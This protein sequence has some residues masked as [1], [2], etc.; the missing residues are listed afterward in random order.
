MQSNRVSFLRGKRMRATLLNGAAIPLVGD[1][2]VVTTKGFV[3][4]TMS[5][6]L[7]RV[8]PT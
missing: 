1:S 2:S 6:S 3:T 7:A 4:L 8:A 5:I